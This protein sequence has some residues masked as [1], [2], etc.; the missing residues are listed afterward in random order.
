MPSNISVIPDDRP[1]KQAYL[2]AINSRNDRHFYENMA[3]AIETLGAREH[4]LIE[5]AAKL[6]VTS[7]QFHLTMDELEAINDALYLLKAY[8]EAQAGGGYL[9]DRWSEAG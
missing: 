1:W 2:T 7:P 6:P 4:E 9:N 5:S 8:Y 3:H